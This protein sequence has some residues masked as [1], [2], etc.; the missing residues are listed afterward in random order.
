[1]PSISGMLGQ[2]GSAIM[3]SCLVKDKERAYNDLTMATSEQVEHL[4]NNNEFGDI[5]TA[6]GKAKADSI[7][8]SWRSGQ[9]IWDGNYTTS[10]VDMAT[11]KAMTDGHLLIADR[12]DFNKGLEPEGPI[13]KAVNKYLSIPLRKLLGDDLYMG[14]EE[15]YAGKT[16]YQKDGTFVDQFGNVSAG[17][18][19]GDWED[20]VKNNPEQAAETSHKKK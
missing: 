13:D 17:G 1:M 2:M 11:G 8:E 9:M 14:N 3:D 12:D 19:Q 5:S 20:L 10:Y 15:K 4:Y 18:M 6:E 16:G 7:V